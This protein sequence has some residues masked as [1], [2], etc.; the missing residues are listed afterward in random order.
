VKKPTHAFCPQC[1]QIQPCTF[2]G[3]QI[4]A[5]PDEE[6]WADILCVECLYII[7]TV[8]WR[9]VELNILDRISNESL[10]SIMAKDFSNFVKTFVADHIRRIP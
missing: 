7:A 8:R 3:N 9:D 6:P 10:I 4:K 1:R 2:R 5:D